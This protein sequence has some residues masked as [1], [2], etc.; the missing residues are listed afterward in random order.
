MLFFRSNARQ[1]NRFKPQIGFGV[2]FE[3]AKTKVANTNYYTQYVY[4]PVNIGI[5]TD[6][7]N[8]ISLGIFAEI[9]YGFDLHNF[10]IKNRSILPNNTAGISVSYRFSKVKERAVY[11]EINWNSEGAVITLDGL[12]DYENKKIGIV[13]PV[14]AKFIEPITVNSN[15][16]GA[17]LMR[18]SVTRVS[19]IKA[20]TPILVADSILLMQD[21]L[22]KSQRSVAALS[23]EMCLQ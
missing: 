5:Q 18:D 20:L 8:R 22:R 14:E 6:L 15:V 3:E 16:N 4:V 9:K 17:M 2:G 13:L 21:S 19:K 23:Q 12:K 1:L 7:S 10:N 11:P